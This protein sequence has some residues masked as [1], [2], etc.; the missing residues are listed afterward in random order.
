MNNGGPFKKGFDSR[1]NT[2]FNF[3]VKSCGKRHQYCNI[4]KPL[5]SIKIGK[6]RTKNGSAAGSNN[7]S[8]K[9]GRCKYSFVGWKAV[10]KK[11]WERDKVCQLCFKKP[12]KNRKLDVH[13]IIP[14]RM[15]GSD[16]LDNLVGLHHSCHMKVEHSKEDT[17]H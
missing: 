15:G 11:V 13:H 2:I 4:C 10:R 17:I 8:Y 14:R 9:G 12:H 1:R 16:E 3:T 7:P 5:L 6:I